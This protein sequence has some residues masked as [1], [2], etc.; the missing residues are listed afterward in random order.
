MSLITKQEPIVLIIEIFV[1]VKAIFNGENLNYDGI[2]VPWNSLQ[3]LLKGC[4]PD[5]TGWLWRQNQYDKLHQ[6]WITV[7]LTALNGDEAN[8]MKI[9]Q[10]CIFIR[11]EWIQQCPM[12]LNRSRLVIDYWNL[13]PSSE[14]NFF[15]RIYEW[16][17]RFSCYW[18]ANAMTVFQSADQ[19]EEILQKVERE[20][21]SFVPDIT[22]AKGRKEIAFWR[23]KLRRRKHISMVLAKTL[24]LNWRKFQS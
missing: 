15:K 16:S 20:V 18:K 23:I 21:M 2:K 19:I 9:Y 4:S 11:N 5:G 17:N 1:P 12:L 6:A 8:R 24:L 22:T 7:K 3:R 10:H 13:L 14:G